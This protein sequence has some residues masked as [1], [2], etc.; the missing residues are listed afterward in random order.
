MKEQFQ[1]MNRAQYYHELRDSRGDNA[2][3]I[4]K[5]K[6][7]EYVAV[8]E[9]KKQML[10]AGLLQRMKMGKMAKLDLPKVRQL[11][12]I[13]SIDIWNIERLPKSETVAGKEEEAPA[14]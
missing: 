2:I 3:Y 5:E 1:V 13:Q 7:L 4:S 6:T 10:L 9:M 12:Q 14:E 11:C 8:I